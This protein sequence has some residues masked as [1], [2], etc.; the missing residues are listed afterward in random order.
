MS[1]NE[2]K[3]LSQLFLDEVNRLTLQKI[4]CKKRDE[5]DI[6]IVTTI[7]SRSRCNH[8]QRSCVSSIFAQYAG[9]FLGVSCELTYIKQAAIWNKRFRHAGKVRF[10]EEM[11][12]SEI[13]CRPFFQKMSILTFFLSHTKF[14]HIVETTI[15]VWIYPRGMLHVFL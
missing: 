7:S 8:I 9:Q 14:L 5:N 6:D 2:Y 12:E 1:D 13:F 4:I 15:V 10:N 3:M 11:S